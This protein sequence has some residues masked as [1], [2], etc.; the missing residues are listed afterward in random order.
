MLGADMEYNIYCDES[1]HL[2][3]DESNVMVLG[4]V[5]LEKQKSKEV[6]ERIRE[7]KL[8]HNLNSLVELKWTKISHIKYDIYEDLV[9]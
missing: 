6:N 9:R 2:L 7:I 5:W 4:S 8:K 1:N 3:N